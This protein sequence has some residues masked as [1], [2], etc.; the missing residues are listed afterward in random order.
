MKRKKRLE[1]GIESLQKQLEI[2]EEKKKQAQEENLPELVD[3]YEKELKQKQEI[4]R[5][6]KEI[7]DKQ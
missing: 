2:H 4:L 1:K 6:K 7:L 3:Y 5:K